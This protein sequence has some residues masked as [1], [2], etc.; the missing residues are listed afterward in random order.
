M[1]IGDG[2]LFPAPG[3]HL[4]SGGQDRTRA[5]PIL[6]EI[7]PGAVGAGRVWI[8]PSSAAAY[9]R[10]SDNTTWQSWGG[11]GVVPTF[12]AVGDIVAETAGATASA[13]ATG[14]IADAAHRHAAARSAPV[15]LALDNTAATGATGN[16][17]DAGHRHLMPALSTATPLVESGAGSAGTA[18]LS[19]REDHV[20]PAGAVSLPAP[21]TNVLSAD[22]A[23]ANA[24]QYYDGPAVTLSA[25]TWLLVGRVLYDGAGNSTLG[26]AKLWDGTTVAASAEQGIAGVASALR[27]IELSLQATVVIASGTPTWKISVAGNGSTT[28]ILAAAPTNSAGNNASGLYAIK[29]A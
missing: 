11:V 19:S 13:G 28:A 3:P 18:D 26:T 4:D 24:N 9:V 12:G 15:A 27:Y 25:G 29:L 2:T 21:I 22:V 8:V 5:V 10:S 7:D 23:M 16:F 17:S 14:K 6:S 1:T 20:H